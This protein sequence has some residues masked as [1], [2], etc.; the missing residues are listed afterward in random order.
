MRAYAGCFMAGTTVAM[1]VWSLGSAVT[2]LLL[3]P[4][5]WAAMA[6]RSSVWF[7]MFGYYLAGAHDVPAIVDAFFPNVGM[8]AGLLIWMLHAA[9]LATCWSCLWIDWQHSSR[10]VLA[11]FGLICGLMLVPPTGSVHWL[12]PLLA[13]GELYPGCGYVGLAATFL[14][15]AF[16]I[17]Y[18]RN[19]NV[20]HLTGATVMLLAAFILNA[21]D[22]Q[23]QPPGDW[24]VVNT[25]HGAF[26]ADLAGRYQRNQQLIVAARARID[27]GY[28]VIVFPEE[29]AGLW[30]ATGQYW[31][32][33]LV[34]YAKRQGASILLGVDVRTKNKK[35]RDALVLLGAQEGLVFSRQPI[36]VGLWRPWSEEGA[37]ADLWQ[38]G[39]SRV[40]GKK[41]AFSFCY[42]DLLLWPLVISMLDKPDVIVS[43]AN[44]WFASGKM[45]QPDIQRRSVTLMARLFGVPLIRA[46][47]R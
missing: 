26:P 13:A 40:H 6:D 12:S 46:T 43:V 19:R 39:T 16:L 27:A 20:I 21:H 22:V 29:V 17:L 30:T 11:R 1:I 7:S 9:L 18:V 32:R 33:D 4:M 14:L 44:R 2:L 25:A 10:A 3:V 15:M 47:N 8:T 35:Y 31:W 5:L 37:V 28:K 23:P 34:E 41:V 45:V 42:E 24:A 38:W 36:P